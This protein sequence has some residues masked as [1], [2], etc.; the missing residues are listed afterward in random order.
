MS[1]K[2]VVENKSKLVKI[3]FVIH[4]S[5][6]GKKIL[7]DIPEVDQL[8]HT[9]NS[10]KLLRVNNNYDNQYFNDIVSKQLKEDIDI[11]DNDLLSEIFSLKNLTKNQHILDIQIGDYR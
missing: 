3:L 10:N 8:D 9:K 5:S 4:T 2:T 11:S 1:N 6:R 7:L